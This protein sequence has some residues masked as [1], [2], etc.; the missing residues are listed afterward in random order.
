MDENGWQQRKRWVVHPVV[1]VL[2]IVVG[3]G[4][5]ADMQHVPWATAAALDKFIYQGGQL[6]VDDSPSVR[7]QGTT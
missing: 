5:L 1:A 3:E 2:R 4:V 7:P 6:L